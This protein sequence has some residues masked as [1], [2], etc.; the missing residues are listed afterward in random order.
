M[1]RSVTAHHS[2]LSYNYCKSTVIGQSSDEEKALRRVERRR[3]S[4][5]FGQKYTS[6]RTPRRLVLS[7]TDSMPMQRFA[8]AAGDSPPLGVDTH[9]DVYKEVWASLL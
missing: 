9:G 2:S 1:P 8:E 6:C 3:S 7:M 5:A 4:S